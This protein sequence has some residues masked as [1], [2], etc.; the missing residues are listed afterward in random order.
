MIG[1]IKTFKPELKVKDLT[2]YE[3]YY[4]GI[5]KSL[6]KNYGLFK[7]MT[8]NFDCVFISL[9]LDALNDTHPEAKSFRCAYSPLKKKVRV[10]NNATDFTS[11]INIYL[12]YKKLKDDVKDEH[13]FVSFIGSLLLTRSGKKAGKRLGDLAI[14][15]DNNLN[16]LY[17]LENSSCSD[18]N[19]IANF[20][21]N[22]VGDIC[23][24]KFI[25]NKSLVKI[26][27]H[28]GYNIG[29]W[30]YLIDAFD[31]LEKDF[32]SGAYNPYLL[33]YKYTN[34]DINEFKYSIKEKVRKQLYMTV[35]KAVAAYELA[36]EN[37]YSP[38][39]FNILLEGIYNTTNTI[40]EGKCNYGK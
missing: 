36:S 17:K 35:D 32:K 2:T 8:L 25:S 15:I 14:K 40:I 3:A 24:E 11:D 30:V 6:K 5:C 12:T 33:E 39:I 29:K 21:G 9:I 13:K 4:C 23:R 31:D 7:N 27:Y 34:Q 38:L 28:I 37:G 22:V 16:E 20:Y 19:E 10:V 1:Y 18:S 26:S